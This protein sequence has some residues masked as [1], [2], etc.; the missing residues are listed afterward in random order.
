MAMCIPLLKQ[1]ECIEFY[2]LCTTT[3]RGEKGNNIYST[4]ITH[5][6]DSLKL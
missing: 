6:A 4:D 3:T 2:A 1:Q 5:I